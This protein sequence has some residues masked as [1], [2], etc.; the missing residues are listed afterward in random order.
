MPNKQTERKPKKLASVLDK[1]L[2]AYVALAAAAGVSVLA[3]VEPVYADVVFTPSDATVKCRFTDLAIDL[4][5]DG[6]ADFTLINLGLE[7]GSA[8][9]ITGPAG[10][11]AMATNAR[12]YKY[13]YALLPHT[14]IV[15]TRNFQS[16]SGRGT[17]GPELAGSGGL[18]SSTYPHGQFADTHN[19]A[20]GLRFKINGLNHYGWIGFRKFDGGCTGQLAGWAYETVPNRPIRAGQTHES[21]EDATLSPQ[22]YEESGAPIPPTP[23]VL[24]L[25]S[26]GLKLW[27]K[28]ED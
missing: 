28:K 23:A 15:P 6:I 2:S 1:R 14:P 16:F 12:F 18:S 20:V 27:R 19:R 9:G 22:S 25:G 4:N 7:H 21:S 8:I 13:A 5:N 17:F 11:A 26:E 24:S 3:C 10:N